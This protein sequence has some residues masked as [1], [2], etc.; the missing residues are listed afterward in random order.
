MNVDEIRIFYPD[1]DEVVYQ[2]ERSPMKKYAFS[3]N[4]GDD[5]GFASVAA[6]PILYRYTIQ[7]K[8]VPTILNSVNHL[9]KFA[10]PH[11][12][13]QG[14]Q[15]KMRAYKLIQDYFRELHTFGLLAQEFASVSYEKGLD[16]G[17]NVDFVTQLRSRLVNQ[18][19]R[20]VDQIGIQAQMMHSKRWRGQGRNFLDIKARRRAKRQQRKEWD[21]AIFY[22][23]NK[24]RRAARIVNGVWL[25]G[26]DH[27]SDLVDEV[28][29]TFSQDNDQSIGVLAEYPES[30]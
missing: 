14:G 19:Y 24:S 12:D 29:D 7:L 22:L 13:D 4:P 15:I 9:V 18:L 5:F 28:V 20:K 21:G 25:F 23:T 30:F 27:V 2:L 6:M 17:Y 10:E 3:H 16:I 8:K 1:P 26:E 11:R